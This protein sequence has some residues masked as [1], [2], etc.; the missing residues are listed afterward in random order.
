MCRAAYGP[1][2]VRSPWTSSGVPGQEF[3]GSKSPILHMPHKYGAIGLARFS[4]TQL[5][6]PLINH[7]MVKDLQRLYFKRGVCGDTEGFSGV[8]ES[9]TAS[10]EAI[11]VLLA[12][13]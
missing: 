1:G 11:I 10:W 7:V 12:Y 5:Q 4:A 9:F 3:T 13:D 6:Q 8:R 2:K